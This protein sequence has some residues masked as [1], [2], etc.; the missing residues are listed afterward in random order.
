M[1]KLRE[2]FELPEAIVRWGWKFHH[3]GIPTAEKKPDETYLPLF[4]FYVS[5]FPS[6]PFGIEWIRF[7]KNS[8]I[9]PLVQ[10]VPHIAFE[11]ENLDLQLKRHKFKILT[12]PN[13]PG[14]GVRVAMIEHNGAP[15]ELIEFV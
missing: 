8:P 14:D 6:S 15:I 10:K 12:P 5:G 1:K 4:K 13:S 3:I 9:N 2:D 11:V 7:E